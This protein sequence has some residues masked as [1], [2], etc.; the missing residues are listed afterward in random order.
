MI[1]LDR[2]RPLLIAA[3]HSHVEALDREQNL[4]EAVYADSPNVRAAARA[5]IVRERADALDVARELEC[6]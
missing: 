3:L 2:H 6:S 5:R 4:G 1:D